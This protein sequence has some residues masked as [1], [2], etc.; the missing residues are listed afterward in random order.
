MIGLDVPPI[1]DGLPAGWEPNEFY[2][3]NCREDVPRGKVEWRRGIDEFRH[4]VWDMDSQ[5]PHEWWCGPCEAVAPN[6]LNSFRGV[7]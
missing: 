7:A 1:L 3:T 4:R 2:C 5:T 6:V